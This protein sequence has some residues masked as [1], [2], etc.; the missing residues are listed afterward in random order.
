[1]GANCSNCNCTWTEE[2]T[3]EMKDL[4]SSK[5]TKKTNQEYCNHN[6]DWNQKS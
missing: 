2:L 5:E 1:M 6:S 4:L 3:S